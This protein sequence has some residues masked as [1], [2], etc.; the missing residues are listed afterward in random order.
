MSDLSFGASEFAIWIVILLP[1]IL[2]V[3]LL[4]R[5]RQVI[6]DRPNRQSKSRRGASRPLGPDDV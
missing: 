3:M 4:K 1:V 6:R 2:V 5:P